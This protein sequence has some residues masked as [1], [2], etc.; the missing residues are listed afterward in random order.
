MSLEQ[1]LSEGKLKP[2]RTNPQEI[3]QLLQAVDRNIQD[4]SIEVL[5][6]DNRFTIAY[7]AA[8]QL[9]TIILYANGYRPSASK[10]H[11]YVTIQSLRFTMGKQSKGRVDYLDHCRKMRNA[12]EYERAGVVSELGVKEL[13][14]ELQLFRKE[15][16]DW[17]AGSY[18]DLL[19]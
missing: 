13:L 15:V 8:L 10:G 9:S 4:A 17:L 18:P 11:H 6:A 1:W 5:S 2:H 3:G 16:L 14:E 12:S 19:A 7:Q